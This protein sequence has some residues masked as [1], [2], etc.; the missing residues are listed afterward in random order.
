M[1]AAIAGV[2]RPGQGVSCVETAA[3]IGGGDVL[4]D[5]GEEGDAAALGGGEGQRCERA[6]VSGEPGR[7]TTIHSARLRSWWGARQRGR[8]RKLSAP[9]RTKRVACGKLLLEGGEE[10]DGVV[11]GAVGVGGVEGGGHE[12]AGRGLQDVRCR[13]G[14]SEGD[15]GEAVG[16]GGGGAFGFQGLAA[17][18]SEE[19]AVE[20]E[21]FCCRG[22]EREV[23]AVDRVE[24][25]AEESYA[26]VSPW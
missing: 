12:V 5:G 21:G 8:S 23:A 4:V 22:G 20:G 7:L 9:V 1:Q 10:V 24:G 2:S 3:E 13:F 26:H 14:K 6:S 16:E 15:H 17:Y 18:G 25:A 11:G 19:D